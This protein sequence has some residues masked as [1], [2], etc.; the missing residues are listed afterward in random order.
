MVVGPGPAAPGRYRRLSATVAAV[1]Q[2]LAGVRVVEV[3]TGV[4][5]PYAGKVLAD[6]GAE[7]IKVEPVGG[8]PSRLEGPWAGDGPDPE[9][10]P[11]FL[12]LGTNKRSVVLDPERAED[13]QLAADLVAWADVIIDGDGPGSLERLGVTTDELHRRRPDVV[14]VGVTPF[15]RTGPYA[16]WKG[17]EIVTYAMGGPMSAT[18]MPGREPLKLA[19]NI[20]AVQCGAMASVAALAALSVAERSGVG[21]DVDISAFETQAG[22]ID[23]RSAYLMWRI[24]TGRDAPRQGGHRLNIIPA[25]IYPTADGY[26]QIVVAPNWIPR[27]AV[28]MGD[29]EVL[30]LVASPDWMDHPDLAELIDGALH[31]W[32]VTR[33]SDEAMDQGQ[34]VNLGVMALKEP[35]DVLTDVHF[36]ARDFWQTVEH[37]VAGRYEMPGPPFRMADGWRL[38][39]PAPLLDQ[40]RAEVQAE[41][42]A[43]PPRLLPAVTY[44]ARLPLEGL[45]VIDLTVVWAGPYCTMLLQDLGAEVIRVDNPNLFPTAT[46]GA[47]PR[48]AAGRSAD[49]GSIWGA[50]P[51]D[52]P[53]ERPWNRVGPFVVHARGKLGATLDLRTDLGRETFLRLVEH[54]DVLVEN[55]SAKVLD[56]LGVGWDVLSA[57]N[58]RLIAV[59]MPSLGLDGPYA[60]YVG[61][62]AHVE[63]LCGLTSLRGYA[64]HDV[65]ANGATYQMDPASGAAGTFAILAALRRRETTGRGELIEL[66]QAENLLNTVGEYLVDA[67]RT[68]RRQPAALPGN[69]HPSRAPQGAYPCRHEEGV[70]ERGWVV[71]SVGDDA[72]WAGL[73]RALGEPDWAADERFASVT[74]RRA[75]QDEID[76]AIA[77]WSE[78]L[79]AVDAAARLQAEGVPAGP[80]LDESALLA[81]PHLRQRGFFRPNSSPDL[82]R[83]EFPGHLWH[84]NG[85]E[86]A[87]GPINEMGADNDHVWREVVGLDDAEVAALEAE[88]HLRRGYVDADGNSL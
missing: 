80:V 16:A 14:R 26:V 41:L 87:W 71:L 69:H 77:A 28:L 56:Q 59:R 10:G 48:P 68:G 19:G 2:P 32:C 21:I 35:V 1:E 11:L 60:R 45:R 27:L 85:P 53:G 82:G 88:G 6:H 58:P 4:A 23:R 83:H 84:W 43:S 24:F 62:G 8:D 66:A 65:S 15:G 20:I 74:G 17:S 64:D 29:P 73:R 42:A 67:S 57:R 55:N 38:R 78:P 31:V 47:I 7:V 44:E 30:E 72:E 25:G 76:K 13:R 51:D 54:A 49:L 63:A 9:T 40:H 5:G 86:L 81:D 33:T 61:F 39:R 50:F 37:P 46:R 70:V 34:A 18:G 79:D 75:H 52:D 22:S 12:H 36:R 3:A